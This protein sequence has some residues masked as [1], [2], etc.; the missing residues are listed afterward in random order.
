MKF[1]QLVVFIERGFLGADGSPWGEKCVIGSAE[2]PGLLIF[3]YVVLCYVVL[4]VVLLCC[5]LCCCVVLCIFLQNWGKCHAHSDI[6]NV[7]FLHNNCHI[8]KSKR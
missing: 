3:E 7:V 5:M 2:H 4:Y 6:A 8:S 1:C